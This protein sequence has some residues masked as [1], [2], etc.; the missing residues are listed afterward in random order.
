MR[1]SNTSGTQGATRTYTSFSQAAEEAGRSRIYG[2]IHF[3]FDNQGGLRSGRAVGRYIFDH[4]VQPLAA[5]G[6]QRVAARTTY[7]PPADDGWVGLSA[8]GNHADT[9]T[10]TEHSVVTKNSSSGPSATTSNYPK[11][12]TTSSPTTTSAGT[13]TVTEYAPANVVYCEPVVVGYQPV[14]EIVQP[15]VTYYYSS[16]W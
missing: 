8:A 1:F 12:T 9:R 13:P 2:G 4:Y 5:S 14:T 11:A 16:G 3:E 7:R 15:V 10:S 6:S